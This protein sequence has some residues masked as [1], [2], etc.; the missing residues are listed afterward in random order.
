M[1]CVNQYYAHAF[2]KCMGGAVLAP[3]K[4][5][6][7]KFAVHTL[8]SDSP[9]KQLYGV[10]MLHNFLKKEHLRTKVIS[11][12]TTSTK[13][14][15]SLFNMLGWT[16][17]GDKDIRSFAT[18]VTA[19]LANSIRVAPIPGAMQLIPSL[20]DTVHQLE[21]KDP[22]LDTESQE[23]K[24]YAPFQQVSMD[25]QNSPVLKWWK[26]MAIY[27]LIPAEEPS[28]MEE[29]NTHMIGCCKQITK[30]W[31]VPVEEPSTD[32]DLLP[33]LGMSIL[34]RLGS[35]DL[36]N[37]KEISKATGLISKIIEFT[38]NRNSMKNAD[39]A[40]QTLLKGS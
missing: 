15:T 5:S 39:E 29:Q 27:C 14:L 34:D 8:K 33:V 21:I 12:L 18:K 28:N 30:C 6:L 20:L 3:K 24:P 31:Y 32:Q 35:F 22:L 16:S 38:S 1:D 26:K 37:C 36:E 19:E 23:S 17:E 25:G 10:Q 4:I 11:E 7:I 2:E 13:T 9:K 40:H